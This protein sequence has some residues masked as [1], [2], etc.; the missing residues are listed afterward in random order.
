MEKR[1]RVI[2]KSA[3][4]DSPCGGKGNR[5]TPLRND[6]SLLYQLLQDLITNIF[7]GSVLR[8]LMNFQHGFLP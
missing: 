8:I 7:S 2:A 4:E 6:Q 5:S 3:Q 1:K